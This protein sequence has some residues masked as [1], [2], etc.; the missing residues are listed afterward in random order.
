MA[1]FEIEGRRVGPDEPTYFIADIAANH[2]GDLDRARALIR[3][4][5][6]AGADAAKFQHFRAE[7][8]VS[9][10]GF[11]QLGGQIAHQ[12]S[13]TKNVVEVYREASV[14]WEW[15]PELR[16]ECD[17][18]GITFFSSPYDPGSVDH[19]DPYVSVYKVGSG[20]IDWLE[21][22]EYIA[23]KGK[24]VI[25]A[26]GAAEMADVERAMAVL[27]RHTDAIGL[28]QCNTNY[29]ADHGNH[30]YLNLRVLSTYATRWPE[31]VLGLS[32][33]THGNSAVLG[34][35]ALGARMVERHFTDDNDREGPDHRFALDPSTWRS[36]VHETRLLEAALGS[37][38]KVVEANEA[39]TRIV[40]RRGLWAARD[41][42]VGRIIERSDLEVLRP[43]LSDGLS[44]VD[45]E[46]VVGRALQ[47][48]LGSGEA[49]RWG[50]VA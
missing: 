9:A 2:D 12:A 46:A 8:I 13:W 19:I 18:V 10:S 44:P 6:E 29:T 24:P 20:D 36:M 14:P 15:T 3:L 34:A 42:P 1:G 32:D 5:H 30:R 35:V 25:V 28:M 11:A 17:R 7:H 31:A 43:A 48:P 45:L 41:L 38:V 26:T 22:L 27:E 39:D 50:D 47:R 23:S 4:A 49:I 21:E 40:Q 37:G 33:H 16:R